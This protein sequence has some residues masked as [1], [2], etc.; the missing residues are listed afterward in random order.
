MKS[1]MTWAEAAQLCDRAKAK[2]GTIV[3]TNG[4]FDVLHR[5]HVSYLSASRSLGDLLIVGINSDASVR[6]LKGS[7]RP[8]NSEIDRACLLAALRY[9]DGVCVFEEDTPVEWLRSLKP[10]IHTKGADYKNQQIP[11]METMAAWGGRVSFIDFVEN[12]S[13]TKLISKI[14]GK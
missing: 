8:L 3:T 9:V 1:V 14:Q 4:C 10:Q 13:T 12:Y 11:E 6:K 5:G 2:G 7:G